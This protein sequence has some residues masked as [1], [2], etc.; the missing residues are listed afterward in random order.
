MNNISKT[1]DGL[2]ILID[3]TYSSH[4]NWMSLAS[5]YSVKKNLPDAQV[6]VSVSRGMPD[7]E[8]FGWTHRV[9]ANYFQYS[10]NEN[11]MEIA[12][13]RGFISNTNTCVSVS[14][15]VMAVRA[16]NSDCFGPYSVKEDQDSTLVSYREGC[17][18]FV[19]GKWINKKEHPFGSSYNFFSTNGLTVNEKKVLDIWKGMSRVSIVL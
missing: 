16:F 8:L 6:V 7:S 17:G 3:S 15:D 5:W 19:L 18:N 1:G 13:N 2:S 12:E 14:P 4:H 10:N 11:P 9:R